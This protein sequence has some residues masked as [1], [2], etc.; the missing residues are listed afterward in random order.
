M[1]NVSF[2]WET[3]EWPIY[4]FYYPTWYTYFF[5]YYIPLHGKRFIFLRN[6]RMTYLYAGGDAC[7]ATRIWHP[8]TCFDTHESHMNDSGHTRECVKPLTWMRP[9]TEKARTCSEIGVPCLG[10]MGTDPPPKSNGDWPPHNH[11]VAPRS[12]ENGVTHLVKMRSESPPHHVTHMSAS[13]HEKDTQCLNI[14][15]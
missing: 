6:A 3:Q 2:F 10:K 4:T 9:A 8:N 15:K 7:V 14:P 11:V 12:S 13:R 1:V 5:Y